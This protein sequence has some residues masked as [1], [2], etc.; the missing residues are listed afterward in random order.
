ML[1]ELQPLVC[2]PAELIS[3]KGITVTFICVSLCLFRT[4]FDYDNFT[5]SPESVTLTL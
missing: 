4:Y 2:V 3:S 1:N 5:D